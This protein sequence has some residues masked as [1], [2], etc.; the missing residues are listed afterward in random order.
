VVSI[1]APSVAKQA[2]DGVAGKW[3]LRNQYQSDD[4]MKI[5]DKVLII[6]D[7]RG[8]KRC[9]V[10]SI[11]GGLSLHGRLPL[12][13]GIQTIPWIISIDKLQSC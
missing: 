10:Q 2:I 6:P 12:Q 5:C 11:E 13:Y 3:G 9:L 8:F 7:P 1:T 4:G